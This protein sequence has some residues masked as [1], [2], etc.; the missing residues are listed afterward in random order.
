MIDKETVL[1][2]NGCA[3]RVFPSNHLDS[4]RSLTNPAFL[5]L[6]ELDFIRKSDQDDVRHVTERYIGN[7]DPFIVFCSTPNCPGSLW[8]ILRRNQSRLAF[9]KGYS[10]IITMD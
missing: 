3:I 4:F 1:E 2:F 9:T 6:D 7:L 5:L 8:R 10:L